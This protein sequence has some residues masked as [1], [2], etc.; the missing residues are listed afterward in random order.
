MPYNSK[1]VISNHS[2]N[3]MVSHMTHYEPLTP[4]S[5]GPSVAPDCPDRAEA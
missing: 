3:L 5:R 1:V 4:N 2:V